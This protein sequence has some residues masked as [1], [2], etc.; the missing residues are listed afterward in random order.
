MTIPL[1]NAG[2]PSPL[3]ANTGVARPG[4]VIFANF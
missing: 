3:Q 2:K 1:G 4:H